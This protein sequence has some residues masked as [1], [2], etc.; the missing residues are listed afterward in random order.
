MFTCTLQVYE[1]NYYIR[2]MADDVKLKRVDP[3]EETGLEDNPFALFD[4]AKFVFNQSSWT[5]VNL[6][7]MYMRYGTAPYRFQVI[8]MNV[9]I[10][11]TDS[12]HSRC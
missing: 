11:D 3:S 1:D 12:L 7:H 2:A 8:Y 10:P 6:Y 5:A 9:P 4:G